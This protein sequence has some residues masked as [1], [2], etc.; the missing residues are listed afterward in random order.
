[1]VSF[2]DK[3][4]LMIPAYLRGE[5][6]DAE[7]KEVESLAAKNPDIAADIEFQK[8]LKIAIKSDQDSFEPGDL[9][10]AKLSKAISES[11]T[12]PSLE[13]QMTANRPRFWKYS[14][15]VLAV[16]AIG[17]AGIL[18]S[19]AV[20]DNSNSQ[21]VT[22]SEAPA[23]LYTLKAGF[24][25]D[26]TAKQLTETLQSLDAKIISGPSSLGLYDLEFE[27]SAACALAVQSF[28][29]LPS[30]IATATSCE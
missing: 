16:A 25:S 30:V 9:G 17:Q 22:A 11:T 28:E 1:M 8:S 2:E 13:P 20:K 7:R 18:S 3:I 27:T 19:L 10:W 6:S 26:V 24:N 4:S 15:V 14:A 29:T 12:S 5:L 21:Y 23:S